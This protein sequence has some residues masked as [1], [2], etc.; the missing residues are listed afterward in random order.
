MTVAGSIKVVQ[1]ALV[2]GV[3]YSKSDRARRLAFI[4][5]FSTRV[6]VA[7]LPTLA[8]VGVVNEF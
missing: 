5:V 1:R 8:S 3:L 7:C 4:T 2:G 6:V